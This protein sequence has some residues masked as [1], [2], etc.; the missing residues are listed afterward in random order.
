MQ[1]ELKNNPGTGF[2]NISEVRHKSIAYVGKSWYNNVT[3]GVGYLCRVSS[4]SEI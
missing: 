3:K 1:P 2:V 4:P